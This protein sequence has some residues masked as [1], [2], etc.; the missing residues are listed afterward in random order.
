MDMWESCIPTLIFEK[1]LESMRARKPVPLDLEREMFLPDG[2]LPPKRRQLRRRV[3]V[4]SVLSSRPPRSWNVLR[5]AIWGVQRGRAPCRES[6]G[7]PQKYFFSP[8]PT[9]KGAE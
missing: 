6:E 2:K 4:S 5:G 1:A 8:F 3:A 7:V 9:G